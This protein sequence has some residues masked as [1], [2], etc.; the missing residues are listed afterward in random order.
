VRWTVEADAELRSVDGVAVAGDLVVGSQSCVGTPLVATWDLA[1][2]EPG[3][4]GAPGQV[5]APAYAA[6]GVGLVLTDEGL[7]AVDE[8]THAERWRAPGQPIA[9]PAGGV[10]LVV[11]ADSG[12][13]QAVDLATG[14]LR[15]QRGDLGSA[16]VVTD[17]ARAYFSGIDGLTTVSLDDGSTLWTSSLGPGSDRSVVEVGDGL[18]FGMPPGGQSVVG[19]DAATGAVRWAVDG[20]L[21]FQQ[22]QLPFIGDGALYTATPGGITALDAQ[23]GAVRW[24]VGPTS[25]SSDSY[26]VRGATPGGLLVSVNAPGPELLAL[27]GGTGEIRWRRPAEGAGQIAVGGEEVLLASGCGGGVAIPGQLVVV[28]AADGKAVWDRNIPAVPSYPIAGGGVVIV[29]GND[30]CGPGPA[31][32]SAHDA[33]TGAEL[34]QRDV[35]YEA[36]NE[37]RQQL[38]TNGDV[39]ALLDGGQL[40]ALDRRTGSERWLRP[41]DA[42]KGPLAAGDLFVVA[43]GTQGALTAPVLTAFRAADGSVAWTTPMPGPAQVLTMAQGGG[44]V[45]VNYYNADA[46]FGTLALDGATGASLWNKPI[47]AQDASGD[48]AVYTDASGV[49]ALNAA[50]GDELWHQPGSTAVVAGDAVLMFDNQQFPAEPPPNGGSTVVPAELVAR[51]LHDGAE[52]WRVDAIFGAAFVAGDLVLVADPNLETVAYRLADGSVAWTNHGAGTGP[53]SRDDVTDGIA[54]AVAGQPTGCGD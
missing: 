49:T 52:R 38:A 27:N 51:N 14:K 41:S 32:V 48:I 13:V 50:T 11:S 6:D 35:S 5:A 54:I 44:R 2:G 31:R 29:G 8:V 1:T 7:T 20:A 37:P 39:I 24:T 34:W 21:L 53:V 10:L 33:A 9:P 19:L 47:T 17:T 16:S 30:A 26:T 23:T 3:A 22:D 36:P 15:W 42:G 25:F 40:V 43:N 4:R 18:V 28:R 12:P 45:F 46:A